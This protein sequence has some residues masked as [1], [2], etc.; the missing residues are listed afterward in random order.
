M[1]DLINVYEEGPVEYWEFVP[2]VEPSPMYKAATDASGV[3]A[4]YMTQGDFATWERF[5]LDFLGSNRVV[6]TANSMTA[7]KYISREIPD[8]YPSSA[9]P[10]NPG[11][12]P[13]MYASSIP[14][15][16]GLGVGRLNPALEVTEYDRQKNFVTYEGRPY[17]IRNDDDVL[18]QGGPLQGF[19]DEGYL[20][21]TQG[22]L[23]TRFISRD[24]QPG[25]RVIT[26]RESFFQYATDDTQSIVP[27]P[28]TQFYAT[29]IYTHWLVPA[30]G[31]PF[32]AITACGSAVNLGTFDNFAQGTLLYTSCAVK[33]LRGPLGDRL[34][35]LQH[36]FRY[37]PNVAKYAGPSWTAGTPLGHNSQLRRFANGDVD[38]DVLTSANGD[39]PAAYQDFASLFRPDQ[40]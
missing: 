3:N 9:S 37:L 22:W 30:D 21:K 32:K 6:T 5:K 23:A 35:I 11:G 20:L 27:T 36:Q 13:F 24:W 39:R 14:Q 28:V 10:V 34:T 19:P 16:E 4:C 18:A 29:V 40:S 2:P 12:R 15:T 38:Y 1:P 31:V 8:P 17:D 7:V 25:S 33:P 26:L